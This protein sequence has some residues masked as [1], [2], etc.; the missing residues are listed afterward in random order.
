MLSMDCPKTS[1]TNAIEVLSDTFALTSENDQ[2]K[3]FLIASVIGATFGVSSASAMQVHVA[4]PIIA[5]A[6][7]GA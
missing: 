6:R 3:Y 1:T 4:I 2:S 5:S 7:A